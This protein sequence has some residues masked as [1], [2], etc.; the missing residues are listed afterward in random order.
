MV[1][2][3]ADIFS[4]APEKIREVKVVETIVGGTVVWDQ[5]QP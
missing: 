4:I 2:L 5:T 3:S 1:L